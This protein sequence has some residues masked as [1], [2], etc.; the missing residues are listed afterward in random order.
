[1]PTAKLW[2]SQVW[3]SA[4]AFVR[5]AGTIILTVSVA[6]WF[7]LHFPHSD[8][9][10]GASPA[11]AARYRLEHSFAGSAGHAI[12]PLIAPL[13]LTAFTHFFR[14]PPSAATRPSSART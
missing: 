5:R 3:K 10:S 13:G 12:E 8:P 9:P 7:L 4:W 2:L 14:R 6:L 1:M 11:E